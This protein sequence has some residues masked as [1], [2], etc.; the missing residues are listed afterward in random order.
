M[1]V[2]KHGREDHIRKANVRAVLVKTD[3]ST[4]RQRRQRKRVI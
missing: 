1:Q 2:S 3:W 4:A